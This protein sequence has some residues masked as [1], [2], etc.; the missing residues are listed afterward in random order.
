MLETHFSSSMEMKK[1][2]PHK[3]NSERNHRLLFQEGVFHQLFQQ[4]VH[5][6]KPLNGDLEGNQS[7]IISL[8][9]T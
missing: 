4:Q 9:L 7:N 3:L 1:R 5:L 6:K 8:E 2:K